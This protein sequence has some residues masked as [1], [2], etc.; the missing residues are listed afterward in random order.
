MKNCHGLP[1]LLGN[2]NDN[3]C[4]IRTQTHPGLLRNHL[5]FKL[6]PIVLR[7][8]KKNVERHYVPLQKLKKNIH[9][10]QKDI[11]LKSFLIDD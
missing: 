1:V 8:M 5:K 3:P 9:H 7:K 4:S 11:E 10:K 2:F 6:K